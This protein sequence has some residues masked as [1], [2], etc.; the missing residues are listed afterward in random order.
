MENPV[1]LRFRPTDKEIVVDYLRPK[2][3][4]RDTSH[5]DRVISTVTIRSFDPWELPCQSRI[6][7]KDESWCFF[8]PKENKYGRGDQQIRKTKS[9]YWK[10]TGK[11]KPI[12]RNR[13]EIGEKKVLMFYMSKELGG[14]KSDW[15]MHEYHAFSPTQMMMT[16]T[17]CKV[18]F[19]GDVREISSSSASSYGS[20]IEQSRDSLIPLLV[21]DSEEEAQIED[22]IP[23][24][25]WE[26]WLTD[27]GVDEQVN[28]IMNM[29]DDR[30]NHR[31]QKPLTGVLIDDSS[32]DDDDSDLLSPTT[33]SIEN[34]STC[35]S[36]G[37]SD[38]INLVSLTQEVSQALI[39]SIDTPEKIKSPYDDAQGTGAGEQKL[40]QERREKKRAGFFHRMIQKFVKKFH[41]CSSISRT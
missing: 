39:T 3:S 22:A 23:I 27:D 16:Y 32:D 11:P 10:I 7:L 20:E 15:V 30:N 21:N 8:S 34:S 31:P 4:D 1:G 5:V 36:F 19:K 14:S 9:G 2:N 12:L 40:G 26:T 35:D 41:L 38:Q 37:S 29:K 6:K 28:H 33:N 25:E 18:M 13:Q 24:E 17:I